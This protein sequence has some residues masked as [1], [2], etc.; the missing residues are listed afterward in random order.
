MT[1]QME[2][3]GKEIVA[4]MQSDGELLRGAK[5]CPPAIDS[6]LIAEPTPQVAKFHIQKVERYLNILM[7]N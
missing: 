4:K 7:L 3:K 2:G 1:R 5:R 6:L